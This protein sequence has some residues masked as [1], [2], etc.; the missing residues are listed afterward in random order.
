MWKELRRIF[1]KSESALRMG[2]YFTLRRKRV[3][4]VFIGI[5]FAAVCLI[6]P[7]CVFLLKS[8]VASFGS[9][10]IAVLAVVGAACVLLGRDRVGSAIVLSG[11]ELIL[12]GILLPPALARSAEY[13]AVLVSILGMS[14][15]ALMP[16]GMM[17]GGTYTMVMG[18]VMALA[19]VACT[20]ISGIPE[21]QGR[22]AVILL[23]YLLSSLVLK[24]V[25]SLQ[26][27]LLKRAL[28][29][30]EKSDQALA[31]LSRMMDRVSVLKKEADA[32]AKAI[33]DSF[34]E[35]S[36]VMGA[37][38]AKNTELYEASGKLGQASEGA[39]RNLGLLLG[40]IEAISDSV[41]RQASLAGEH[42]SSQERMAA[43]FETIRSDV[44]RAD[45]ITRKLSSLA[46]DGKG[47]LEQTIA[48]V[49]GLADYQAKTLE[50][51][52][53]LAKISGQTNMLAM[54]AAIEAAHAGEAGAGF[55]VVAESVRD[56]A[57]SSGVRTKEI[58]TIVRTMNEQI[59]ASAARIETV[60]ASLFQVIE[61]TSRAYELIANIA[62]T[63]DAFSQDNRAT[64]EG[65]RALALLAAAIKKNAEEERAVSA[66][67]SETFDSLK[68]SFDV[69]SA[70]I[71]DLNGHNEQ[72]ARILRTAESARA[73]SESVNRAID[74]LLADDRAAG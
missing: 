31:S 53:T 1:S 4:I 22:R 36:A 27:G 68:R 13:P 52:G 64:L 16:M 71:G 66:S 57:D 73:E 60:A 23:V 58:S 11:L 72:S 62:R 21:L 19:V 29:E 20:T 32:S 74:D 3:S 14:L 10:L 34:S 5:I 2:E 47:T 26:D 8:P 18:G 43:A 61:E 28:E 69:I 30:R 33:A 15:I 6:L 24:Y 12:L 59:E 67:F 63:M 44:A 42:S 45:E 46:E 37:F 70:A 39:Q 35:V 7:V 54:N 9:A 51:V 65:V 49:K 25:T 41:T 56:L 17:V 40:S 55:A 48:G 38:M 50:I